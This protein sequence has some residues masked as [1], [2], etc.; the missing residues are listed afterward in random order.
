MINNELLSAIEKYDLY[1]I[2]G[3]VILK[4]LIIAASED[5]TVHLTVRNLSKLSHICIQGVY[6]TL[7][8]L[9]NDKFIKKAKIKGHKLS[10]FT[11]NKQELDKIIDYYNTLE[12]T[13]NTLQ[14]F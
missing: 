3:R 1:S 10:F 9:E 5:Y 4:T 7:K 8:Q 12:V 13:K 2:Q 14:K 11:L 6:N